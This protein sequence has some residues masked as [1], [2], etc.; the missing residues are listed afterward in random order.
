VL[1]ALEGAVWNE[2]VVV[3][4]E[5]AIDGAVV[6]ALDDALSL[7]LFLWRYDIEIIDPIACDCN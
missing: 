3:S 4:V 5:C 1:A 2:H 6:F 7:L